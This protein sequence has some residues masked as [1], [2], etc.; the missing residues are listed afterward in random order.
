LNQLDSSSIRDRISGLLIGCE[1]REGLA[2]FSEHT[3]GL[4]LIGSAALCK[5]YQQACSAV[6][7]TAQILKD[8]A[9]V[10]G[11]TQLIDAI[12]QEK[13]S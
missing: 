11:F 9:A 10:L 5:R 12:R 13:T 4:G 2:L 3:G 8:D 6:D 1:L 7:I